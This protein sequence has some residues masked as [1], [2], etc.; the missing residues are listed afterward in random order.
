MITLLE[1]SKIKPILYAKSAIFQN[2]KNRLIPIFS[3]STAKTIWPEFLRKMT[4]LIIYDRINYPVFKAKSFKLK[5]DRFI[6]LRSRQSNKARLNL[7]KKTKSPNGNRRL[8]NSTNTDYPDYLSDT[9]SQ[10]SG[11]SFLNNPLSDLLNPKEKKDEAINKFIDTSLIM[12]ENMQLENIHLHKPS[13]FGS[14]NFV[15]RSKRGDYSQKDRKEQT[16]NGSDD[17]D[18]IEKEMRVRFESESQLKSASFY[19][20]S[21][22]KKVNNLQSSN[23]INSNYDT[24]LNAFNQIN[25]LSTRERNFYNTFQ[26]PRLNN[27]NDETSNYIKNIYRQNNPFIN[28][29]QTVKS[30]NVN[31]S[32]N[33][34]SLSKF[35]TEK[36]RFNSNSYNNFVYNKVSS[37]IYSKFGRTKPPM[38]YP[39]QIKNG[40]ANNEKPNN[41]EQ[42]QESIIEVKGQL[43]LSSNKDFFLPKIF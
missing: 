1:N 10:I 27:R 28:L 40:N 19:F 5:N 12:T 2:F 24:A 38:G 41:L 18:F 3:K 7:L 33:C 21:K 14:Y 34:L 6:K 25:Q 15:I 8:S 37:D 13:E 43:N 32:F 20:D 36:S 16:S 11:I 9:N 31:E 23:K 35:K 22:F 29:N 30:N 42:S 26:I 39:Q 4:I 17:E